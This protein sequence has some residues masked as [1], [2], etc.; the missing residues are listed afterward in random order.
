M[1]QTG[2]IPAVILLVIGI[3]LALPSEANIGVMTLES[4]DYALCEGDTQENVACQQMDG[5]IATIRLI[6]I[7]TILG[8]MVFIYAQLK[9]GN[10]F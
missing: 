2:A 1:R 8:D 7:L 10:L 4:I 9:Q 5:Y 6:G 3:A